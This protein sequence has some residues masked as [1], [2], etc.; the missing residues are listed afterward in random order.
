MSGKTIEPGDR[1]E[2]LGWWLLDLTLRYVAVFGV[3]WVIVWASIPGRLQREA[4]V[5]PFW[6]EWLL[7]GGRLFAWFGMPSLVIILLLAGRR[8][9][10]EQDE[11]RVL[12]SLLLMIPI[13]P[14]ML[15][16]PGC[17]FFV[18]PAV[19]LVFVCYLLPLPTRCVLAWEE[20][21]RERERQRWA[22]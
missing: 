16:A 15:F 7:W 12:A 3:G 20:P 18:F 10:R 2:H 1:R 4:G 5:W 13:V 8:T 9:L 19:Q 21:G 6:E 17:G 22:K 11:F 14:L